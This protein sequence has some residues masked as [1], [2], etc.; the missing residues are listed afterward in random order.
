MIQ[1]LKHFILFVLCFHGQS[2]IEASAPGMNN[3]QM[4]RMAANA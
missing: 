4:N 1:Q 3:M 2:S